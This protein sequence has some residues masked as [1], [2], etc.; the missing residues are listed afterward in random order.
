[1]PLLIHQELM[2]L[3]R[4][5]VL[6]FVFFIVSSNLQPISK[7]MYQKNFLFF[8]NFGLTAALWIRGI[9]T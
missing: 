9:S 5:D 7:Q 6:A 3:I 8:F 4:Y 2:H 1:M